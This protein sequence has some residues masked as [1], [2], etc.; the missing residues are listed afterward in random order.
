M[1][2][3]DGA[4]N[5]VL[6]AR[7]CAR[8]LARKKREDLFAPGENSLTGRVIDLKGTQLELDRYTLDVQGAY[9]TLPEPE[10]VVVKPP[11]E[12]LD[13]RAEKG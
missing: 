11:Q 8:D 1:A 10:S 13:H 4:E 7:L 2:I 3:R 5:K 9:N 6:K 12:W